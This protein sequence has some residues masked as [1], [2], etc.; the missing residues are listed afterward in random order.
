MT[1]TT[2]IIC[3]ILRSHTSKEG[4]ME[5]NFLLLGYFTQ[6]YQLQHNC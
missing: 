2:T 3:M 6:N 1:H 5:N 4:W